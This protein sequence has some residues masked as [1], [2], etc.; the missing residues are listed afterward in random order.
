MSPKLEDVLLLPI[1]VALPDN[2]DSRQQHYEVNWFASELTQ[3][4]VKASADYYVIDDGR[5]PSFI[6]RDGQGAGVVSAQ[7]Q[8]PHGLVLR[9]FLWP[10]ASGDDEL[11]Q[12]VGLDVHTALERGGQQPR[13]RG[14]ARA[15]DTRNDPDCSAQ[16]RLALRVLVPTKGGGRFRS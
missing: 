13:D 15:W 7:A 9:L 1:C 6:E 8:L 3:E 5:K 2:V 16:Y 12:E 10:Q 11:L 4:L 14:L